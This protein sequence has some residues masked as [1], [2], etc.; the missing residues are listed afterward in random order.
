MYF[1]PRCQG[2]P[3]GASASMNTCGAMNEAYPYFSSAMRVT[4]IEPSIESSS[5]GLS[6]MSKT[7]TA[8]IGA[9]VGGVLLVCFVVVCCVMRSQQKK[10]KSTALAAHGRSA[11][12]PRVLGPPAELSADGNERG[13][14]KQ[15]PLTAAV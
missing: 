14:L 1:D 4:A 10:R 3:E 12:G 9:V 5:S 2:T 11:K 15:N 13:T 8:I 6:K 7:T